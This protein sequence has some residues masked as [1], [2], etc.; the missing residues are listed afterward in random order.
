MAAA[1]I[2][3]PEP[4]VPSTSSH[5]IDKYESHFAY[6]NYTDSLNDD[7]TQFQNVSWNAN[8]TGQLAPRPAARNLN[9][10][11]IGSRL[12]NAWSDN[13]KIPPAVTATATSLSRKSSLSVRAK[14]LF[15]GS[16]A[17]S[18]ASAQSTTVLNT[19]LVEEP[20]EEQQQSEHIM[21]YRP[22]FT[23]L[24]P[25]SPRKS[26]TT[27]SELDSASTTPCASQESPR[28]KASAPNRRFS[29]FQK[30]SATE[31]QQPTTTLSTASTLPDSDLL[32]LNSTTALLPHGL[33]TAPSPTNFTHL[34]TTATSLIQRFQ[35]AHKANTAGL[36]DALAERSALADEAEEAETRA[37]IA[38]LQLEEVARRMEEQ[39]R[40]ML[41]LA[42]ELA[43]ERER[44]A[45][46][47]VEVALLK[48]RE[49]ER[50][51]RGRR[52]GNGRGREEASDSGFESDAETEGGSWAGE[53]REEGWKGG[54]RV[55]GMGTGFGHEEGLGERW[56]EEGPWGAMRELREEN[57]RLENR[58]RE[59]EGVVEGCLD[60]VGEGN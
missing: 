13:V 40:A 20:E 48:G 1:Q 34:L 22:T 51:A 43:G 30:P 56:V 32:T 3:M 15:T 19:Q 60:L 59:L 47:E 44:R 5:A 50:E 2:T 8:R 6:S 46:V 17:A 4:V 52:G 38:R 55:M 31:H 7:T 37:R 39:E 53:E 29:W 21:E 18:P 42:E 41:A 36:S 24:P 26:M 54:E 35:A 23:A 12:L 9:S 33:P 57:C 25:R 14:S 49:R 11:A 58:V 28:R 27:I 10:Q 16:P 45:E